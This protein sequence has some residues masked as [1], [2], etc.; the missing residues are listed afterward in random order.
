[1]NF[2]LPIR[3]VN[4]A[5]ANRGNSRIAAIL[6][7]KEDAKR[8]GLALLLTHVAMASAHVSPS[9]LLPCVVTITRASAGKMDEHDGLRGSLKRVV[10]GIAKAL[11]V[12]DG[13]EL[14]EWR[15]AQQKAKRGEFAVHV[16]IERRTS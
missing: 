8:K 1:M 5:N 9:D 3:T 2:T 7:A 14:V 13:S 6:A 10:D 16:T 4:P 11:G 15:Y 12:D